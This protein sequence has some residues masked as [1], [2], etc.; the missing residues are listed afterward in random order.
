VVGFD[1]M[2]RVIAEKLAERIKGMPW[3]GRT[4]NA[5]VPLFFK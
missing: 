1:G 2:T 4:L 3:E 5:Y